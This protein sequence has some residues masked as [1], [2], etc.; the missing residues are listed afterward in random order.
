MNN[1]D[2]GMLFQKVTLNDG[3]VPCITAILIE[4]A[5]TADKRGKEHG[6]WLEMAEYLLCI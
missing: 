6:N 2:W 1:L 3:E 4:E 5:F